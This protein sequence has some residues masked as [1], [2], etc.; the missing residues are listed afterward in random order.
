MYLGCLMSLSLSLL[1]LNWSGYESSDFLLQIKQKNP[2]VIVWLALIQLWV[3]EA[4]QHQQSEVMYWSLTNIIVRCSSKQQKCFL[5]LFRWVWL[6]LLPASCSGKRGPW[7]SVVV[8]YSDN[9]LFLPVLNYSL[10]SKRSCKRRQTCWNLAALAFDSVVKEGRKQLEDHSHGLRVA[11]GRS[12][13]SVATLTQELEQIDCGWKKGSQG[14]E[15]IHGNA[16]C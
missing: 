7:K 2:E 15:N 6:K 13:G 12:L 14:L 10:D 5:Q 9:T 4:Q 1:F 16:V 3:E 8:H 11:T